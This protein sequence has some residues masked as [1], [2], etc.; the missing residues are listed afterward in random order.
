MILNVYKIIFYLI[1]TYIIGVSAYAENSADTLRLSLQDAILMAQ[2]NS[3]AAQS[4]R[5][6]YLAAYWNYRSF[7]ANYLPSVSMST[8]PR[9]NRTINSVTQS[10]GTNVFLKQ[11]QLLT[12]VSLRVNQNIALTGGSFFVE[13]SLT[14]MDELER[15]TKAFNAMPIE[16]GYQQSLFGYN[17]LKWDKKIEPLAF[18][19]AKK[20]YAEALELVSAQTCDVFF[21]WILA[22][23]N[24]EMARLNYASADTLYRMAQGRYEIGSTNEKDMLM[25]EI[26]KLNEETNCMDAEV[27]L[28]LATQNLCYNLGI[29]ENQN[30]ILTIPEDVPDLQVPMDK[31]MILAMENSPRPDSYAISKIQSESNLAY[32]KSAAGLR[33]DLYARFG[34]S[35]TADNVKASYKDMDQQEY[36]SLTVTIPIL[37]WGRG[38]GSVKV[39]RSRKDFTE[40]QAKRGMQEFRQNVQRLVMQYNMQGRKVSV[41]SRT[42]T[43]ANQSYNVARHLFILGRSTILDLNAAIS[44]KDSARRNYITSM[45]TYWSIYY[46]L[47]S[48]TGYDFQYD[49]PLTDLLPV[50]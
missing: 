2:R 42:S 40:T 47:R 22:Q 14:R 33:A 11:N 46:T 29:P 20:E 34:L 23:S 25:L 19:L 44:A 13:T 15:N 27:A 31:A 12:D 49:M 5:H 30:I 1:T 16:I 10:D 8:S 26:N 28:Q 45:Q 41:A 7:R 48:L 35:Q 36:V 39:A 3:P 4:A 32:A 6:Q 50:E 17:S 43:Q 37:D 21:N 18:Q 38:K 24:L 9:L